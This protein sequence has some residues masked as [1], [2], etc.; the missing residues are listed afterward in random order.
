MCACFAI[1]NGNSSL[2]LYHEGKKKIIVGAELLFRS[3]RLWLKTASRAKLN[4][5]MRSREKKCWNE[6]GDG[7]KSGAVI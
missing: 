7:G 5:F 2:M 1:F 4:Y 3:L 6:M